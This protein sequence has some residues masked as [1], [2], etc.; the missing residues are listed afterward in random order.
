MRCDFPTSTLMVF[1]L[2]C[3]CQSP[4]DDSGATSSDELTPADAPI[5]CGEDSGI[6]QDTPGE[7]NR[8]LNK[9][10]NPVSYTHLTLP[11][12]REV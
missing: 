8:Y 4:D 5:S 10:F 3:G 12:N 7:Y 6:I 11:T 1:S 2:L 9:G